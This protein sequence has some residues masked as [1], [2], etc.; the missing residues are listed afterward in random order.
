MTYKWEREW[1]EVDLAA[2]CPPGEDCGVNCEGPG[3]CVRETKLAKVWTRSEKEVSCWERCYVDCAAREEC[4]CKRKCKRA[5]L[6]NNGFS[7]RK[8][9]DLLCTTALIVHYQ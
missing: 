2:C 5:C 4:N 9:R 8:R 6:G 7:D 3:E 1:R